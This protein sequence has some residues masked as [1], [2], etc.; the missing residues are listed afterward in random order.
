MRV[1]VVVITALSALLECYSFKKY[2]E[3]V[4][5]NNHI[6]ENK[7]YSTS[8]KSYYNSNND[9]LDSEN[10][11]RL[12]KMFYMKNRRYSP[13]NKKNY[14]NN[15]LNTN[16][17]VITINKEMINNLND[18]LMKSFRQML[19]NVSNKSLDNDYPD[20]DGNDIE[21][22]YN[23]NRKLNDGYLDSL[24]VYRYRYP[25]KVFIPSNKKNNNNMASSSASNEFDTG[26]Q[27]QIIKNS[28]YTFSDIGGYEKVKSEL[29]QT[30]DIL[31]NYDKYK[32][33]NV[34]T[35]KGMIFEG[36][37]GNGKTL[38]A[39]C[40]SGEINVSFIPVS[41]SEF[42]EKYVGVGASRVRELFKLA[43]DNKPCIIF[44]DEI[45]ALARKRGNDMI[46][47]NSEK[48]Q[49]LNQLLISLDGFRE[50]NGVFV[51]GATNRL[52]LL[53]AALTRAGRMDKNIFIGNPDSETR[54]SIINIH[55]KGKPYHPSITIDYIVEMTGGFSGAQ[56]ENLLNEAMLK[57]LRD[58]REYIIVDDLEFITNRILSGWQSTEN[59][60]SDDIIDKIAI[61]EMGHALVGYFS[62]DHPKLVKICLNTW[63]P[64]TPGYT[65]FNNTDENVNIYTK[66]G[67]FSHL[68]VLLSGRIA[69]EVFYGYSVTTGARKDF[70]EAYNLAKNMILHYGMG[71][72]NIYPDSSDQSKFL[73]D[74]EINE[75]IL[76]AQEEALKIITNSKDLILYCKEL[77][78]TTKIIKIEDIDRI[79]NNKEKQTYLGG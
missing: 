40:F 27:F 7:K 78:K 43:N 57:A 16:K 39:K 73:I 45:D 72:Q 26:S 30:S 4:Y 65:I 10:L 5:V 55:L 54:K 24:G 44:I 79:I 62:K 25:T 46:T 60:F 18:E 75:L 1:S 11:K 61:H 66:N 9:Y 35:P 50:A 41:G 64:K 28:E 69:E 8:L 47:S 14:M 23:N 36:P 3:N 56:I 21:E 51:I 74:Q 37:P 12:E 20:L 22:N 59:K 77:L 32:K 33:F 13:Y 31:I 38:M 52:D 15:T 58:D 34:R 63:S 68:M 48:D 49:T 53:D 42:S 19:D 17:E 29:L 2:I 70:E 6:K 67:L 71:K 76:K